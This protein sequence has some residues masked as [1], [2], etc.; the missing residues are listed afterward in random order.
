MT[1]IL[2]KSGVPDKKI[3]ARY[4]KDISFIIE[5]SLLVRSYDVRGKLGVKTNIISTV[6]SNL[7]LYL[8]I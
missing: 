5:P 4:K 2:E 8:N 6:T 7:I 3:D 1:Q